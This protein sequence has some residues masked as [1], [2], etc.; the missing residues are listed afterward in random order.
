[1]MKRLTISAL[2]LAT[3]GLFA[4]ACGGSDDAA[5]ETT[6]TKKETTTTEAGASDD[7]DSGS[8][9]VSD[10]E[11]DEAISVVS[12]EITA[13]GT[14]SCA[15]FDVL[16]S[17]DGVDLPDPSTQNQVKSA[18]GLIEQLFVAIA[19]S[20]PPE[21]ATE[22]DTLRNS[23]EEFGLQA[24]Q[25]D[26]DPEWINSS[27]ADPFAAPGATDALTT[28]FGAVAT[29]CPGAMEDMEGMAGT[30]TTVAP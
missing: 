18:V 28:Y 10:E 22:A 19:D 14:D 20:A 21:F 6:T 27:E 24:E 29:N 4:G 16:N 30:E 5:D 1:M 15:L 17:M 23:I 26:Y 12:D 7:E 11:F 9:E 3:L 13:A 25:N 8:D 2:L